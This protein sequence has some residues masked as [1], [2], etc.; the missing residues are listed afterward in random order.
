[1]KIKLTEKFS[2]KRKGDVVNVEDFIA[3]E[4][5]KEGKAVAVAGNAKSEDKPK[6]K[7]GGKGKDSEKEADANTT[8]EPQGEPKGEDAE[9]ITIE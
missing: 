3:K 2:I 7:K 5:I 1:M 4:L 9:N 8:Q 6:A